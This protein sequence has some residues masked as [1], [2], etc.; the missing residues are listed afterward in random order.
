[1]WLMVIQALYSNTTG[2]YN[3]AMVINHWMQIQ[4]EAIM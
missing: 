2:N 4:Q 3:V 1:M